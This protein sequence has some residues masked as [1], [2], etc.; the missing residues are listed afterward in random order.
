M[1][2]FICKYDIRIMFKLVKKMMILKKKELFN[3]F[4]GAGVL[5]ASDCEGMRHSN[6]EPLKKATVT[7]IDFRPIDLPAAVAGMRGVSDALPIDVAER[8]G[9]R[10][11]AVSGTPVVKCVAIPHV[12][13]SRTI[14]SKNRVLMLN[15]RNALLILNGT[16]ATVANDGVVPTTNGGSLLDGEHAALDIGLFPLF[17]KFSDTID[18]RSGFQL[19]KRRYRFPKYQTLLRTTNKYSLLKVYLHFAADTGNGDPES[20]SKHLMVVGLSTRNLMNCDYRYG[21]ATRNIWFL[22]LLTLTEIAELGTIGGGS[23]DNERK[24]LGYTSD[25][26]A[27]LN[28]LIESMNKEEWSSL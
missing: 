11:T 24:P 10:D 18:A 2:A 8:P 5:L 17:V 19:F 9:V 13:I 1:V 16:L 12:L 6:A 15:I 21:I 4:L 20:R 28:D 27:Q 14:N 26:L 22:G 23:L 3:M 25:V 7:V